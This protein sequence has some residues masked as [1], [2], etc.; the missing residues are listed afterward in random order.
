MRIFLAVLAVAVLVAGDLAPAQAGARERKR[1]KPTVS[2]DH[3]IKDLTIPWP[4]RQHWIFND[5]AAAGDADGDG[6]PDEADQCPGTPAGATVDA[7][8]CPL[9]S[10]GDGVYD[11]IDRCPDTGA[12][13]L[14]DKKGCA[15]DSDSDGVPDGPDKC[16]DTPRGADVDASGCPSDADGDGV[17]DGIDRCPNTPK[18]QEVDKYGCPV[19]MSDTETEFLD[20]GMI[21]TSNVRFASGKAD[22]KSESHAVLDE[23]G[24]ILV[25]WPSLEIEIGGHTDSQGSE[26]FNQKLSEDRANSVRDYLLKKYPG[27]DAGNLTVKGYGESMPVASNDTDDGRA[28]NRRVEFTVLNKETLQKQIERKGMKKRR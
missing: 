2:A 6:V 10:D 14:V 27:I 13:I 9:D 4:F 19:E 23:I 25:Q 24:G 21:R 12:G 7:R 18:G 15:K 11:G 20:T 22:L 17:Y 1:T 26:S 16:P 3:I 8:G 28:K 5:T